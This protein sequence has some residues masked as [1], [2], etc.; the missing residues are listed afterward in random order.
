VA[1]SCVKASIP[2][3]PGQIALSLIKGGGWLA[4]GNVTMRST[5]DLVT[6]KA[7]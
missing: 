6:W 7:S 1:T 4:I 5:D 2:A 3:G